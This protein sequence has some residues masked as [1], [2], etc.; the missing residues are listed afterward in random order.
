MKA[1]THPIKLRPAEYAD[2]STYASERGLTY[3]A[4]VRDLLDQ[5]A[6]Q[7]EVRQLN[8]R[9]GCLAWWRRSK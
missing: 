6:Q 7:R 9:R 2:L 3:S 1:P 4:A 8:N 5:A